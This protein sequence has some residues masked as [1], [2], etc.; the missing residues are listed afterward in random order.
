MTERTAERSAALA[1]ELRNVVDRAESL[2]KGLAADK[3]EAATHLRE[4]VL[5]TV[6][7]AKARLADLEQQAGVVAQRASV[8]SEAY[9]REHPWTVVGGAVAAGLLLGALFTHGVS[10]ARGDRPD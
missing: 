2:L 5:S 10:S 9:V 6:D 8:A 1:D 3:D 4:R 7:T